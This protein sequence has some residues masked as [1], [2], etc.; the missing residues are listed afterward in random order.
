[1]RFI[2][3]SDIILPLG[4]LGIRFGGMWLALGGLGGGV[5]GVR[6]VVVGCRKCNTLLEPIEG[7]M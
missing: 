6:L 1:M 3:A 2:S 4:M 7:K 5:G